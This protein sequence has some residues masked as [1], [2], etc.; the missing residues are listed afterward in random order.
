MEKETVKVIG[1]IVEEG[2]ETASLVNPHG[3][4]YK[5]GKK[6]FWVWKTC[7]RG[8]DKNTVID[9]FSNTFDLGKKEAKDELE[10]IIQNLQKI[11]LAEI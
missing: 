11:K 1:E 6:S 7:R 5:L 3:S 8:K 10:T 2:F 4:Q 9:E